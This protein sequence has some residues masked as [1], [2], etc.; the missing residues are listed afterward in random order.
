MTSSKVLLEEQLKLI[1]TLFF[2]SAPKM[3]DFFKDVKKIT[4]G[5]ECEKYILNMDVKCATE[6]TESI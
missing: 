2:M 1:T 6:E 5:N 3:R 4:R